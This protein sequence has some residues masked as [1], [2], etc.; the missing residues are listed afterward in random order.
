MTQYF[1]VEEYFS[2]AFCGGY[3]FWTV[4]GQSLL[5]M[6]NGNRVVRGG[7]MSDAGK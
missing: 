6:E 7:W 1:L 5:L 2:A 4:K 3:S